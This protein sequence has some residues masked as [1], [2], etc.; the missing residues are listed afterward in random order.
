MTLSAVC[1]GLGYLTGVLAFVWMARRRGMATSGILALM[2]AGLIGGLLGANAAQ[3]A[4]GGAAGKTVLG[5]VAGGYLTVAL[6]K[7]A[8][9]IRRPTGDLFAVAL[10]AG[11]A[12]GRWGCFFGGCC[13]GKVCL[14]PWAVA[15][16][17]ALRHPTQLY[18]SLA[19][20]LIL[21]CLLWSARRNPP[22]NGLFY[23]QGLLYCGA[24]FAVEFYREVGPLA[25]GLTTAQWVCLAGMA[26][27]G[28]RLRA[29][30]RERTRRVYTGTS[31]T[32]GAGA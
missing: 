12:V 27:F 19:C 32:D 14:F 3:W 4:L 13:Y 30:V 18:L 10:C 6:F 5:G 15:Q 1:Y 20:L 17:G 25:L 31:Q 2:Q 23:L 26:F 24:R 7:R 21:A 16:H 29:L 9:G 11:E 8:L 22:E 28:V